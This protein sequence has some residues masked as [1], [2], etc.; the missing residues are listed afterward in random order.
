LQ[1]SL[2]DFVRLLA[3]VQADLGVAQQA[4]SVLLG[5]L[6]KRLQKRLLKLH[7]NVGGLGQ[8]I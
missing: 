4:L 2:F 1:H 3:L 7:E 6:G 5:V 8:V